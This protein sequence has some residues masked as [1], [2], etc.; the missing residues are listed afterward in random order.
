MSS[1]DISIVMPALN[2]EANVERAIS[3]TIGAFQKLNLRGEI[4]LINDGSRDRTGEIGERLKGAH[5]FIQVI[6]HEKPHGI[7]GSFWEGAHAAHGDVVTMLPGDGEN[8]PIEILRYLPLM[9]EVDIIV[10]FVYNN[11]VRGQGRRWVSRTYKAIINLSFGLLLNYMNGTV[12]YRKSVLQSLSLN[13][14]GFFYQTELLI[15]AIR[16][17][18]LY[19]EVPYALGVRTNGKSTALTM[20]SFLKLSKDYLHTVYSVYFVNRNKRV[21]FPNESVTGQRRERIPTLEM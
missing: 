19:A 6:H 21:D 1:Y 3:E 14:R 16:M 17:G 11:E 13:S 9:K 15:K 20:K 12:V 4:V 10:P 7:G 2:E 5:S 8:D 18:F